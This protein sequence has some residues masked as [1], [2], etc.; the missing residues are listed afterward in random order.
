MSQTGL[1]PT[2][3]AGVLD[4]IEPSDEL[5]EETVRDDLEGEGETIPPYED[6]DLVQ[7]DKLLE[8]LN[9][10]SKGVSER[11]HEEYR[12]YEPPAGDA[13]CRLALTTDISSRLMNQCEVFLAQQGL[14]ASGKFF[15]AQ[16]H[17][18]APEFIAVWIMNEFV[19]TTS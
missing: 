10:V 1:D 17:E 12:R 5:S 14:V 13:H 8:T 15:S 6:N 11:T 4:I 9:D 7:L 19:S 18:H 3:F 16:P 2:L